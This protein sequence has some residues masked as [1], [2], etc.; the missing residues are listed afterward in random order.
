M[1][2]HSAVSGEWLGVPLLRLEPTEIALIRAT[3]GI[4]VGDEAIAEWWLHFGH[5]TAGTLRRLGCTSGTGATNGRRAPTRKQLK[6][7]DVEPAQ[8]ATETLRSYGAASCR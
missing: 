8:V 7:Y 3:T 6:T 2:S 5:P 4:V 1:I